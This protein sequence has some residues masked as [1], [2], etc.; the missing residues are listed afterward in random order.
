VFPSNIV[1]GMFGFKRAAMYE[2][3]ESR[4]DLNK[5]PEVQF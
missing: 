3:T 1:A 4:E 2:A 5:A